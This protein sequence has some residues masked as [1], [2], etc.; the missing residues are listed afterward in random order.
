MGEFPRKEAE[1]LAT[2][3]AIFAAKAAC[4]LEVMHRVIVCPWGKIRMT[5]GDEVFLRSLAVP[6]AQIMLG[7][8]PCVQ[9]I[10]AMCASA[11]PTFFV[12]GFG[13]DTDYRHNAPDSMRTRRP[14]SDL[15][16]VH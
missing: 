9:E 15:R 6:C 16:V 8:F 10:A 11:I 12:V 7:V 14:R 2:N 3:I 13:F 5:T 1:Q 4:H